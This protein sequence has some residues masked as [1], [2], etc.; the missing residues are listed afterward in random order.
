MKKILLTLLALVFLIV[1]ASCDNSQNDDGK[2][3]E[4]PGTQDPEG[5]V[6]FDYATPVTDGLKLTQS[7][8]GKSF[9]NDGIGEVTVA[10]FVDG[11]TTIFRQ[12]NG[13]GPN[14][15]GRYQGINTPE[16]T[17]TVEPWGYAASNFT[18]T[19]LKNAA[20]IV[21]QTE[22]ID[23]RTDSNGRYLAWVWLI[24]ETGDSR[25]LNLELCERGLAFNKANGTSLNN[26]FSESVLRVTAA[27]AH[28][29]GEKDPDFDY[30]KNSTP[31]SLKEIR[32][33]YGSVEQCLSQKNKGKRVVVN[34]VVARMNGSTSCYL[35]QYDDETNRFYG[36]YVYGGFTQKSEFAVGNSVIIECRIGYYFGSLQLTDIISI[37]LRAWGDKT[38]PDSTVH[39]DDIED[40]SVINPENTLLMGSFVQLHNLVV[41]GGSDTETSNAFTIRCNYTLNGEIKRL[42]IR[43]DANIT[44]RDES[45]ERITT[46]EYF[47]GKTFETI[48]A[49]VSYYDYDG[50][51]SGAYDGYIQLMLTQMSDFTFSE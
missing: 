19:A 33:S 22:D 51:E 28:I 25:L 44:L 49:V 17:Y 39:V 6:D 26:E 50:G 18:K 11:D 27:R 31:M 20:K 43:V 21:L 38:N 4:D 30:S 9:I 2:Q 16:S 37:K 24:D 36:V 45:N 32:E 46:Y 10:Q 34:G 12:K 41:V 48:K 35:Q 47:S 8:E 42:D 3:G 40:M 23:V 1:V 29:Y 14:F 5:P 7:Y 13:G 15:T